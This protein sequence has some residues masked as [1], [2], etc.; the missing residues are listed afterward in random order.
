MVNNP[1]SE[2]VNQFKTLSLQDPKLG[3]R[4]NELISIN[5]LL[6]TL[7]TARSLEEILDIVL[8]TIL[9]QY[10]CVKGAVF[11]KTH[12][13]WRLGISKGFGS[14]DVDLTRLPLDAR[15][16][17]MPM[18]IRLNESIPRDM[19][20]FANLFQLIFPVKNEQ[21]LVG[22][23]CLGPEYACRRWTRAGV[24]AGEHR[25]FWRY[26]YRQQSLSRRSRTG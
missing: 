12:D 20:V 26:D 19:E 9:G 11:I 8:L 16:D 14:G 6:T 23:I 15:W 17:Q 24:A 3:R 4:L 2:L 22:L 18:I 10:V 7:N 25:R 1:Y 13:A 21:K 5:E